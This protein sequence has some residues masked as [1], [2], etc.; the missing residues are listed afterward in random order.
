MKYF[1]IFAIL[2]SATSG[3]SQFTT[4]MKVD[5]SKNV[6][7]SFEIYVSL[8]VGYG[9]GE[10]YNVVYYCDANL[11][12]GKKLRKLFTAGDNDKLR[13]S[14][15]VGI[16][17]I[18]SYHS[19]R[20]RDFTLPHIH[21]NDTSGRHKMQGQ[22]EKFYSYMK[23]ELIPSINRDFKTNTDSNSILG[24]SLGGLFA[25][26]CLF[27]CDILFLKYFAL[28]PSLWVGKYS[29][30][31][32]NRINGG[33]PAMQEIYFTS[34]SREKI[35]K[36]L[37]GTNRAKRFFDRKNYNNLNYDYEIWKHRTHSSSVTPTLKKILKEKL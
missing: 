4:T 15:F 37:K 35:N 24:H 13:K 9:P 34:G 33:F 8:P 32:F 28:S 17:H 11:R 18:G 10:F 3:Y 5:H 22:I 25:F 20:R 27:K 30:Y 26:Y 19:R 16:G 21:R 7:D 31:Q 2:F 36:I 14:I 1:F 29:I 12:S 6:G 23:T